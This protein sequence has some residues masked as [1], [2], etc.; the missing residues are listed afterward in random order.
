MIGVEIKVSSVIEETTYV[1][2][3]SELTVE[4]IPAVEYTISFGDVNGYTTPQ[5]IT[6]TPF[7][8]SVKN[9]TV[10]YNT[11]LVTVNVSAEEGKVSGYEVTIEKIIS[12]E[13]GEVYTQ[14]EYIESNKSQWI[15]TGFKPKCNTRVV[16]DISNLTSVDTFLFGAKNTDASNASDQFAMLIV[17][18]STVR[19]DY[20]GTNK[21]ATVSNMSSRTII[22]KNANVVNLYGTTITNTSVSSGASSNTLYLFGCNTGDSSKVY[23]TSCRMYSCQIYDNGTLVR[24]Y[25]PVINS[26]GV[27]GLWDKT[28]RTFCTSSTSKKFIAGNLDGDVIA[29]QTTPSASYKIPYGTSY[30]VKASDVSGYITPSEQNFTASQPSRNVDVV[31]EKIVTGIFIYRGSTE[32]GTD[33]LIPP[34]SWNTDDND[35][36]LGVAVITENCKFIMFRSDY[37]SGVIQWGGHGTDIATLT[38]YTD[39]TIASSDFDGVSN[40]A[41]IIETLGSGTYAAISCSGYEWADSHGTKRKGYV[42]SAGEW[43]AVDDNYTKIIEALELLGDPPLSASYWTSTEE[44]ANYAW[45]IDPGKEE[46][47]YRFSKGNYIFTRPF[48]QLPTTIT[49]L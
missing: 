16:M 2:Q 29:T 43:K 33:T 41:K 35:Y 44:S 25:I 37:Y 23:P 34:E 9:E 5:N 36:A 49:I 27:A 10:V 46:G 12:S 19:S 18:S 6:H 21:S 48:F 17:N 22:D 38:N 31:Y 7:I 15:D 42:G 11:E 3:G 24:D 45:I 20:F 28:N 32:G 47:P 13:N 40:S 26:E 14:I 8:G 1:W 39:A 30:M 4:I